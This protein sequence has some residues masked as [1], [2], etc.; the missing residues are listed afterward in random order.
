MEASIEAT[1]VAGVQACRTD[2]SGAYG[3]IQFQREPPEPRV[4][5]AI[6]SERLLDVAEGVLSIAPMKTTDDKGQHV[7]GF[8]LRDAQFSPSEKGFVLRVGFSTKANIVLMLSDAQRQ[9][10]IAT[11]SL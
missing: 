4:T 2:P 1:L 11:L 8:Q 3:V 5:V 7:F 6:P 9:E 10:L